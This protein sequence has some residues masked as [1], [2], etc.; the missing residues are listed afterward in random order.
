[1][2]DEEIQA[3]AYST[4]L[5]IVS[6]TRVTTS[7]TIRDA[8]QT[9]AGVVERAHGRHVDVASLIRQLEAALNVFQPESLVLVD[10]EGHA[11]WIEGARVEVEWGFAERYLRYLRERE[12]RPPAV[13]DRLDRLT[14]RILGHLE[15]PKRPGE[16]DRRGLVVGQVQSGKTGN[17]VGLVCRAV[18]A[19]YPLVIVMAGLHNSLR[20]Q[21]QL[22]LD[23]GFLGFDTQKRQR[24]DAG[25]DFA[26]AALGV[27]RLHGAPRIPVASLT[28]SEE[29][30][31]FLASKAKSIPLQ[32]GTLPVLLVVKKHTGILNSLRKWILDAAGTGEPLLVRE[33]PLLLLDDEADNASI[34]TAQLVKD[35][36]YR[37]DDVD[38][39]KVNGAIRQLL[40][41]FERKSY[42]GY[43]ATPNANIYIAP[44]V[45]HHEYGRDLFPRHFIEFVLPPTNYFG[46]SRLFGL[47][48]DDDTAPQ[49]VRPADDHASWVPDKH[50]NG[51]RPGPIPASLKKAIRSFI[52]ARATR[53]ARGQV[54]QHNSMLI[55]VTRFQSVQDAVRSQVQEELD[56]IRGRIRFGN[57]DDEIFAELRGIWDTDIEPTMAESD[58]LDPSLLVNWNAVSV[59]LEE[60]VTPIETRVIN[61]TAKEALEY[62]GTREQGFDVIAIGGNKLSRGLTLEGLTVSYYLRAAGAHDTLLQMGRWFG[63]ETVRGPVPSLHDGR[64][65]D[66]V[67]EAWRKPTRS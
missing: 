53:L 8:A 11:P 59:R 1:M 45:E 63:Y 31:D 24:T 10:N 15:D 66:A 17:Y 37:P 4:A 42:V 18:D 67:S 9:S 32:L 12:N 50:L 28:T 33:F 2:T 61:G 40:N 55:H 49:L 38:P 20:S 30:G 22:R 41:A 6:A 48:Q 25:G 64:T 16:W 14:M 57:N 29:K 5:S 39:T 47:D 43:T 13:L 34:N 51:I 44:D 65:P 23:Q 26:A 7:N 54:A 3:M 46:P 19:G 27:G 58:N 52:V 35:G 56:D 36:Q 21:T 60:A 62:F